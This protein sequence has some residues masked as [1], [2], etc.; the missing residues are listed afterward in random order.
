V[1]LP[2]V[3]HFLSMSRSFKHSMLQTAGDAHNTDEGAEAQL[4]N[5]RATPRSGGSNL[6]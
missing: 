3:C 6:F 5:G 1:V 2:P 4:V